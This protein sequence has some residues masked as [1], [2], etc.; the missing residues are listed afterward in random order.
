MQTVLPND[1][2]AIH[3]AKAK[4]DATNEVLLK[5]PEQTIIINRPPN[6]K[7]VI[8]DIPV[9]KANREVKQYV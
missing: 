7:I 8:N 9:D 4:L 3:K 5:E 2:K 6:I 1:L